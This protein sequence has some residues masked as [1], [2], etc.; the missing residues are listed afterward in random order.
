MKKVISDTDVT[1][2]IA[3]I[4]EVNP[5]KYY[6]IKG[7]L[8]KGFITKEDFYGQKYKT[9]AANNV[10]E[11]NSW[12]HITGESLRGIIEVLF[13]NGFDVFEFNTPSELFSWLALVE[14]NE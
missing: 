7:Y 12:S 11:G 9:L 10:T 1:K 5:Y 2:N 14:Y 6:G 13:F 8:C 4:S 3:R